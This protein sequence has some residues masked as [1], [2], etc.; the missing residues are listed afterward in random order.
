[1][2]VTIHCICPVEII[3]PVKRKQV[4]PVK[5]KAEKSKESR[6][7]DRKEDGAPPA[8]KKVPS[9]PVLYDSAKHKPAPL[10]AMLGW[11]WLGQQQK[12]KTGIPAAAAGSASSACV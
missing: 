10:P 7:Q 12:S 4:E 8:K 5:H 2:I 1:M 9:G 6:P 3:K 11:P